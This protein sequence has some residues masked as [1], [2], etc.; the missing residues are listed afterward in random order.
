MPQ[1]MGDE[2]DIYRNGDKGHLWLTLLND[3]RQGVP[4]SSARLDLDQCDA[5]PTS[6]N[7]DRNE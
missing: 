7:T 6:E 5:P 1:P 4:S 3:G 2:L